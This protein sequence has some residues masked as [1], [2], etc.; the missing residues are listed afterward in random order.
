MHNYANVCVHTQLYLP[1]PYIYIY[2]CLSKYK[3]YN[4]HHHMEINS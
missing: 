1:S 4:M 3:S 2:A